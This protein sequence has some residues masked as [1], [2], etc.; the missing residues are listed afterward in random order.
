MN[1]HEYQAKDLL[2]RHGVPV[3][4]GRVAAT[5][6]EAAEIARSIP[7]RKFA[8]KAQIQ[9]G[10]RGKAGGVKL[11][12]TSEAVRSAAMDILGKVLVTEQTGPKGQTV[13]KVY[14]EAGEDIARSLYLAVL[15]HQPTG[16]LMLAGSSQGGED[17]ESQ[18]KAD[19]DLLETLTMKALAAPD[20]DAIA[21][22]ARRIGVEDDLL[23]GFAALARALCD[24]IVALDAT[25]IELNPLVVTPQ[26][27]LVAVD[28][29]IVLDDNALLRHPELE[30]L[31]DRDEL[32]PMELEA[33]RN[34]VNFVR[35]DGDIGVAVNGAG[36]ALATND[37]LTDAGGRPANFMDIRT[38][39]TSVQISRGFD[40]VLDTP[41]LKV[42]VVN[43]HGGGMTPCDTIAEGLGMSLRRKNSKIP[44][45]FR[46]AGNNADFA[47]LFLKN[48]GVAFHDARDMG[49]AVAT[50]VAIAKSA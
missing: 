37:M 3:P 29:K 32:D 19:P 20:D 18:L 41:G 5:A 2:S 14:V 35:M 31:R 6:D 15:V 13:R 45:V 43:V 30:N 23:D 4:V 25:L 39:A 28:V 40:L 22:F 49:S 10:G 24:A 44:I 42:L 21:D 17:I 34:D 8:V 9:A 16:S 27:N 33:Q 47:R 38:M 36:L 7:A 46:A 48:C 1:L 12:A 50:A 26:G 11:V